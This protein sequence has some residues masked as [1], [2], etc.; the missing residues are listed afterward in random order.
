MEKHGGNRGKVIKQTLK[1]YENHQLVFQK[2]DVPINYFK[3]VLMTIFWGD[4]AGIW[5]G[6]RNYY[7][8]LSNQK[9]FG[10]TID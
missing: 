1:S 3:K 5:G 9:V 6:V 2:Y 4:I 8:K 7:M 10:T